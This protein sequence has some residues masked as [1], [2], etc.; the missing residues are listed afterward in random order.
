MPRKGVRKG[1]RKSGNGDKQSQLLYRE[2]GQSYALV[3][4]M[5]GNGR[6]RARCEDGEVK[7][8]KIRGAMRRSQWISVGDIILVSLRDFQADKADVLHVYS[9]DDVRKLRK[10]DELIILFPNVTIQDDEDDLIVFE[11]GD[12]DETVIDAL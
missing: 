8:C 6:L 4:I 1:C 5:L 10:Q 3:T 11:T 7:L 12:L 2:D 9:H